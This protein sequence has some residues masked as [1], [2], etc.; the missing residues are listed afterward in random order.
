MNILDPV[1][2]FKQ[3]KAKDIMKETAFKMKGYS[4]PGISPIKKDIPVAHYQYTS[5][6]PSFVSQEVLDANA[7]EKEKIVKKNRKTIK[8]KENIKK[9]KTKV[10]EI[11]SS[12]VGQTVIS[13]VVSSVLA[14]KP[15]KE[16]TRIISKDWKIV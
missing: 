13:N 14:P 5:S 8:R 16:T 4:Y 15:Q 3:Q 7:Y 9:A 11:A 6:T 1:G 10:G 2:I 12:K